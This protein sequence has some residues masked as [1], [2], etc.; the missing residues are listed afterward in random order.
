MSN[1]I[2]NFSFMI[3]NFSKIVSLQTLVI[4]I[5][6]LVA[7]YLCIW[8]EFYIELPTALIAI[9]IVFPIV[10]S[11]N[12]AYRRREEALNHFADLK[13]NAI[14][15]FYA[16]RDWL[17]KEDRQHSER[18]K[19]LI[20]RLLHNIHLYFTSSPDKNT[21]CQGIF[22]VSSDISKSLEELRD[23][24]VSGSEI[25]RCNQYLRSIMID[26]EKMKNVRL[27]RTPLSLRAYS[28]VFLN[29]FPILFAPYFAFIS[30]DSS[31]TAIGYLVAAFYSLV[32]VSL[33]NIQ[34]DL[35]NPY[36]QIGAD[37]LK[38]DVYDQYSG[39]LE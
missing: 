2:R 15:L 5:L 28:S 17:P 39:I 33:D 21:S 7:T 9:A 26:F 25:S 24:G 32:L 30:H 38:L 27:Y 29:S 6:S 11:I 14:A 10:F 4:V 12:A 31:Y 16:H 18:M 1:I 13:G 34:E 23:A 35:E 22:D 3:R 20:E 19:K 8:H 36:D 37:D